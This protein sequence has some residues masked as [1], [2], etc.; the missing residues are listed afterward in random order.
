MKWSNRKWSNLKLVKIE[1]GQIPDWSNRERRERA[2]ERA[3]E[4]RASERARPLAERGASG[5]RE[6][7]ELCDVFLRTF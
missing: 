3:S 7:P 1:T 2:S 6:D 4:K 5:A